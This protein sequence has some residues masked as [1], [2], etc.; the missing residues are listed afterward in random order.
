MW[1]LLMMQEYHRIQGL[2]LFEAQKNAITA[3]NLEWLPALWTPED[4]RVLS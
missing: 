3:C 1:G 2:Q 4:V